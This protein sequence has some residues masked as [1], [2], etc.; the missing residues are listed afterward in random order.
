MPV[1]AGPLKGG[2]QWTQARGVKGTSYFKGDLL[3]L[4]ERIEFKISIVNQLFKEIISV[5]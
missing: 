5:V 2:R 4:R 3:V 1:E